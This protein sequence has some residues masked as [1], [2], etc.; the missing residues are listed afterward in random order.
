MTS[1]EKQQWNKS[2]N[3]KII[4]GALA[5][6]LANGVMDYMNSRIQSAAD[7]EMLKNH[8]RRIEQNETRIHEMW[9]FLTDYFSHDKMS[10]KKNDKS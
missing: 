7:R 10:L 6:V 1:E 5:I 4:V 8:E 9:N 3:K 2:W